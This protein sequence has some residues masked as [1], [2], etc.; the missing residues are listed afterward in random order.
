MSDHIMDKEIDQKMEE[1]HKL[2]EGIRE[3]IDAIITMP[4]EIPLDEEEHL[5]DD[6]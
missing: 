3:N 1:M 6:M 4:N 2:F 5:S